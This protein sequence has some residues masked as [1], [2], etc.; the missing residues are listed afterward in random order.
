[1]GTGDRINNFINSLERIHND[2]LL[3]YTDQ[4]IDL[5]TYYNL[6]MKTN[7]WTKDGIHYIQTGKEVWRITG[8]D[9]E[10]L[11]QYGM[12]ALAM[13][14]Q[15]I[16]L[17]KDSKEVFDNFVATMCSSDNPCA[18]IQSQQFGDSDIYYSLHDGVLDVIKPKLKSD[19]FYLVELCTD[20]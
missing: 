18:N 6:P 3:G 16:V 4:E 1:M 12:I 13:P 8:D 20:S 9:E 10:H 19:N 14:G 17:G 5:N 15:K 2:K 7:T 11:L